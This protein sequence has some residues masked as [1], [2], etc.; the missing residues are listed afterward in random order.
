MKRILLTGAN[1]FVG[2]HVLRHLLL[3]T[4]Y[5]LVLPVSFKY[6]GNNDRISH[7]LEGNPEWQQRVTVVRCDLS[8]PFST[9]TKHRLGFITEI[10]NVAS[11]S[12]VDL[13]IEQPVDVIQNNTSL[14][15][16]LLEYAREIEPQLFLQMSTDEVYGPAVDGYNHVE[17]DAI[18]PSNPYAASKACQEAISFAY[19]RTYGIPVVITNTMNIIG[20][21]QE[22][23]KMVPKTIL[24][25]LSGEQMPVHV[26][27]EGRPGSR[28]YLHARNLADAWLWLSEN[29]EPQM[30]PEFS[31]PSRY[32]IVGKDELDNIRLVEMI[33]EILGVEPAILPL[34]FHSARPGHDRRYSLDG[35][36]IAEAGWTAPV[37]FLD[38]LKK[39]VLW[40][41]DNPEWLDV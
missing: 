37:P 30:Y 11:C 21:L 7:Q 29:H 6:G 19:W 17:W 36:K 31:E 13:S 23:T 38:S 28:Y 8:E 32:H 34:D 40:T 41:R 26:D 12:D 27:P 18:K 10:W 3:N 2:N 24:K 5:E 9:T 35:T 39:T 15:V 4:E 22:T 1:G 16:N 14:I 20:E 25:L 33:A